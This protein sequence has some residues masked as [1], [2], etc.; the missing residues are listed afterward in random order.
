MVVGK[1]TG[2]DAFRHFHTVME[3][4]FKKTEIAGNFSNLSPFTIS[5]E[6]NAENRDHLTSLRHRIPLIQSSPQISAETEVLEP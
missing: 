6:R 2:E 1:T 5:W 3:R 4:I